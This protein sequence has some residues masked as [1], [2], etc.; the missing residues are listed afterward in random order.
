MN[1]RSFFT[2]AAQTVAGA[3]VVLKSGTLVPKAESTLKWAEGYKY[4]YSYRTYVVGK[5]AIFY[6]KPFMMNMKR[7]LSTFE[8][9]ASRRITP[10]SKG[11]VRQFFQYELKK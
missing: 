6:D 3:I 9:V 10:V 2:R 1:R 4:S 5:D 11:P 8:K 7:E